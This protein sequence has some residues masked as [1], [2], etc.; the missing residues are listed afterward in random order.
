MFCYKIFCTC[1]L[2]HP[3]D[4]YFP[5]DTPLENSC[6]YTSLHCNKETPLSF[7]LC[8]LHLSLSTA[9]YCN[10]LTAL[11]QGEIREGEEEEHAVLDKNS[12]IDLHINS[13][14]WSIPFPC[15]YVVC[16]KFFILL[17]MRCWKRSPLGKPQRF[18]RCTRSLNAVCK[19]KMCT[20]AF[21]MDGQRWFRCRWWS[22]DSPLHPRRHRRRCLTWDRLHPLLWTSIWRHHRHLRPLQ[23]QL[24]V[25]HHLRRR[26][27]SSGPSLP[28][29]GSPLAPSMLHADVLS[30]VATAQMGWHHLPPPIGGPNGPLPGPWRL[31]LR[32]PVWGE[33]WGH[34][35]LPGGGSA[36][37]GEGTPGVARP[38]AQARR[39]RICRDARSVRQRRL[40]GAACAAP[41]RRHCPTSDMAR[42][43]QAGSPWR[44]PL[45]RGA[46]VRPGLLA[47]LGAAPGQARQRHGSGQPASGAAPVRRA[48]RGSTRARALEQAP[49]RARTRRSARLR[50]LA[51]H[52]QA[53]RPQARRR[54]GAPRPLAT[55]RRVPGG[56]YRAVRV[57]N[58]SLPI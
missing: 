47:A 7:Y 43:E 3:C 45:P 58:P 20:S 54:L 31:P 15:A 29:V 30:S 18:H 51:R 38:T 4:S 28:V 50:G 34:R 27:W 12:K 56:G 40:H 48:R 21:S 24:L 57:E 23:R 6:I 10:T 9:T 2:L 17:M 11:S 42:R 19:C 46:A 44:G 8:S 39:S 55:A 41:P 1:D 16:A 52:A 53:R 22:V 49:A 25:V 14:V 5:R 37:P 26:P 32:R 36:S 33:G 13:K 35:A